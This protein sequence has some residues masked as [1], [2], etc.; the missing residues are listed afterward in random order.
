MK[1]TNNDVVKTTAMMD[2]IE[3][4][5]IMLDYGHWISMDQNSCFPED[6]APPDLSE[7][8]WGLS[9]ELCIDRG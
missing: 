5:E 7:F 9:H 4:L 2:I 3:E 1:Y 6:R 8:L